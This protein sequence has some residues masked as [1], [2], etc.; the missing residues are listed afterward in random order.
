MWQC[1][2][3]EILPI[4]KKTLAGQ[5]F[6]CPAT[7]FDYFSG[8]CKNL[9]DTWPAATRVLSRSRERTL[10][11]RL[12]SSTQQQNSSF[13]VVERTR[14]SSKCQKIKYAR[15]KR[16]KILFFIVKYANLR[17]FCCRRRC[18]CL[19]SLISHIANPRSSTEKSKTTCKRIPSFRH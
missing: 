13:H 1:L 3:C 10:G 12:T 11:T 2:R 9:A 5:N 14:T 18:G 7:P 15:A 6:H 8:I 17:G 19:S 16:A 4:H